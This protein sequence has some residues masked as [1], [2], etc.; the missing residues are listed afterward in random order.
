[1]ER[2]GRV[3]HEND[4][5]PSWSW[6]S[7]TVPICY[8]DIV[9]LQSNRI[10]SIIS[11]DSSGTAS[12]Q[13]G[14]LRIRG[15][16]R[17]GFVTPIYPYSIREA[18]EVAPDMQSQTPTGV[19]H[20]ITYRGRTFHP[21]EYFIFS[22]TKPS[23]TLGRAS[24][25]W[26]LIRGSFRPDE[27]ISPS[28]QLTFIAVAQRNTGHKSDSLRE[29]HEE[30]DPLQVWTL[31]LVPTGKVGGEYRRVGYAMWEEC[32]W[33]GYACGPKTR[34]GRVKRAEGWL[35]MAMVGDLEDMGWTRNVSGKGKHQHQFRD[36]DLPGLNLYHE[37]AG[38]E[39]RDIVVV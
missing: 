7:V 6:A 25:G 16:V 10:C 20:E 4:I 2:N 11:L 17:T 39:E 29:T 31:A 22:S 19:E 13:T 21:N 12:K 5:A 3:R 35:G 33:Y 32:Y 37:A 26:R 9:I 23:A 27:I 8:S 14:K 18:A 36:G 1:M 15:H 30:T 28:T 38:A 24:P 34:P